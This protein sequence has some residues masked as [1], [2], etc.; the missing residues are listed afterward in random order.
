MR[1]VPD[2]PAAGYDRWKTTP[3]EDERDYDPDEAADEADDFSE[4]DGGD[5]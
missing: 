3:P 2:F 1:T 4:D 5:Y